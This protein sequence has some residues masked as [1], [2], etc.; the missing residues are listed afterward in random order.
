MSKTRSR[1]AVS[2][3][4]DGLRLPRP[5]GVFQRFWGRHP[6]FGDVLISLFCLLL[7]LAPVRSPADDL[8]D[9][10][11]QH[12]GITGKCVSGDSC[13]EMRRRISASPCAGLIPERQVTMAALA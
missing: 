6:L 7:S 13:A 11:S 12:G 10:V 1:S 4:D 2:L 5:P 8:P 9:H 3:E